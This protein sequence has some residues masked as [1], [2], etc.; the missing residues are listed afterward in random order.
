MGETE[1]RVGAAAPPLPLPAAWGL[2]AVRPR[3][4]GGRAQSSGSAGPP[5]PPLQP[6]HQEAP[7][8][9]RRA[10]EGL[11]SESEALCPWLSILEPSQS[12]GSISTLRAAWSR[13]PHPRRGWGSALRSA[14]LPSG[15]PR[16][17]APGSRAARSAP[18]G[19]PREPACPL[20]SHGPPRCLSRL[21]GS[22]SILTPPVASNS[23]RETLRCQASI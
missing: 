10:L 18:R 23:A 15:G 13:P 6:R 3:A 4:G 20:R 5:P 9:S 7:G 12:A 14:R 21:L 2:R 22:G 1:G 19:P 17:R 11:A 8:A 16:P